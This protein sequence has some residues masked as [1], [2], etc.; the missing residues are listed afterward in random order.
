[1]AVLSFGR[2]GFHN[3]CG[4]SPQRKVCWQPMPS[5]LHHLHYACQPRSRLAQRSGAPR[6][7]ALARENAS[8]AR[9]WGSRSARSQ[10]N[11]CWRAYEQNL[12]APGGERLPAGREGYMF[13]K[14]NRRGAE[15]Q[16]PLSSSGASGYCS[17]R[18]SDYC[19]LLLT[20][21][22]L[23]SLFATG[24]WEENGWWGRRS[25]CF[26]PV[27]E[28]VCLEGELGCIL[29]KVKCGRLVANSDLSAVG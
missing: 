20:A 5:T 11:H 4:P 29:I 25:W 19:T 23:S 8:A 7:C 9:R 24:W 26:G 21:R 1:M 2:A 10:G 28:G 3:T 22:E 15:P 17:L 12:R 18:S 27:W 13:L 16:M 6:P 14:A